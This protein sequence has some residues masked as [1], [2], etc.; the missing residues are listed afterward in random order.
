MIIMYKMLS[1][2]RKVYK[3]VL[4]KIYMKLYFLKSATP[5]NI[6]QFKLIL[7]DYLKEHNIQKQFI[8]DLDKRCIYF[9]DALT[10]EEE[11]LILILAGQYSMLIDSRI[12]QHMQPE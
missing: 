10:H 12:G 4:C 5:T 6:K 9:R 11:T 3:G 2:H 8:L 7:E 1:L